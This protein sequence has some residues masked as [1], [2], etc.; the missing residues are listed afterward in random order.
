MNEKWKRSFGKGFLARICDLLASTNQNINH[1]Q[2]EW[3]WCRLLQCTIFTTQLEAWNDFILIIYNMIDY[4]CKDRVSCDSIP[5]KF[6][7]QRSCLS[8]Q[9]SK[10]QRIILWI[11]Y[12]PGLPLFSSG[13]CRSAHIISAKQSIHPCCALYTERGNK[14]SSINLKNKKSLK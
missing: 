6:Q 7:W 4:R 14:S 11:R 5:W 9:Q 3:E 8:S 10:C 1:A 2:T 12:Q 13:D